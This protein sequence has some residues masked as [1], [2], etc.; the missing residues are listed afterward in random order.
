MTVAAV[1]CCRKIKKAGSLTVNRPLTWVE[2]RGFEPLTPSMRTE[3]PTRQ[4]RCYATFP[5]VKGAPQGPVTALT[6]SDGVHHRYPFR[7]PESDTAFGR[8]G[9]KWCSGSSTANC[10]WAYGR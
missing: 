9:L 10:A 3:R 5:H 2:L 7:F 4:S 8:L 6:A 1:C